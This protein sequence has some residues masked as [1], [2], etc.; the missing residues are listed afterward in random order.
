MKRLINAEYK[1][2][3]YEVEVTP[4]KDMFKINLFDNFTDWSGYS[5]YKDNDW[6]D[7][8]YNNN[9]K[10]ISDLKDIDK[11]ILTVPGVYYVYYTKPFGKYI[12]TIKKG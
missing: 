2:L 6:V 12:T 4:Y 8:E 1:Y 9:S 5:F 3:W 7:T 10:I 11:S